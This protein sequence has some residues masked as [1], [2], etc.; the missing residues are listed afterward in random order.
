MRERMSDDDKRKKH[1]I[2]EHRSS[3]LTDLQ[4]N[5]FVRGGRGR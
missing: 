3:V 5:F 4:D 1:R 2:T